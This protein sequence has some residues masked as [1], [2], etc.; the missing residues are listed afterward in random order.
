VSTSLLKAR[1]SGGSSS[2]SSSNKSSGSKSSSNLKRFSHEQ[3][4][5]KVAKRGPSVPEYYA[6][7]MATAVEEDDTG[8]VFDAKHPSWALLVTLVKAARKKPS[9]GNGSVTTLASLGLVNRSEAELAKSPP[10]GGIRRVTRRNNNNNKNSGSGSNIKAAVSPTTSSTTES[11]QPTVSLLSAQLAATKRN[12]S[13]SPGSK[14]Q[15]PMHPAYGA[16][17]ISDASVAPGSPSLRADF[18]LSA[19]LKSSNNISIINNDNVE[20]ATDGGGMTP[21]SPGGTRRRKN[22]ARSLRSASPND[23]FLSSLSAEHGE[24]T[25]EDLQLLNKLQAELKEPTPSVQT[26]R[27]ICAIITIPAHLRAHIWRILLRCAKSQVTV[28][29]QVAFDLPNQRVIKADIERTLPYLPVFQDKKVRND[30]EILLTQYCKTFS[31]SYKQ[32]MNYI[33]APFFVVGLKTRSEIYNSYCALIQYFLPNTF[34]DNEFG[35]LQCVFSLF[36]FLLLYHDPELCMFL[37]MHQMGPE[38][39][40][41]SW[42]ITLHANRCEMSVLLCLWDHLLLEI[43]LDPLLHY[44]V[45]LALL[46]SKR[47][48]L[49]AEQN[50]TL[51]ETLSKIHV[52]T[53]REVARI[54]A[55]AKKL[56]AAS[57]LSVQHQ[58]TSVTSRKIPVDSVEYETLLSLPCLSVAAEELVG[59][60]YGQP[61]P[62]ASSAASIKFIV[63]DCRPLVQFE[64]GHLPCAFHVDP[65]LLFNDQELAARIASLSSMRGCH[66]CFF[67]EGYAKHKAQAC[68]MLNLS[69]LKRGFKF[70]SNCEGGYERCHAI[71]ASSANMF[72]LVDHNPDKCHE[73]NSSSKKKRRQQQQQQQQQLQQQQL[74]SPTNS[75][76]GGLLSSLA[77]RLSGFVSGRKVDK[78]KNGSKKDSNKKQLVFETGYQADD[79]S[80]SSS[81]SL[82]SS[83]SSTAGATAA[84]PSGSSNDAIS[85]SESKHGGKRSNKYKQR[86]LPDNL[87]IPSFGFECKLLHTVLRDFSQS[88]PTFAAA[89]NRF[90]ALLCGAAM[91]HVEVKEKSV[92]NSVGTIFTGLQASP[93]CAVTL[94]SAGASCMR[95]ALA[96]FTSLIDIETGS[97]TARTTNGNDTRQQLVLSLPDDVRKR[98]VLVFAAVADP[99]S[100]IQLLNVMHELSNARVP[101]DRIVVVALVIARQ[102]LWTF[103]E[104]YPAITLV[105]SSVDEYQNGE[106]SPG[107]GDF[108]RRYAAAAATAAATSAASMLKKT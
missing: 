80:S 77:Q 103:A 53:K 41:S 43:E 89:A 88:G 90:A 30:M 98:H 2:S 38:L 85:S 54:V 35:G 106:L 29:S 69:F 81:S 22:K 3:I 96:P 31:V 44:F 18:R 42:F 36:R 21:L 70:I 10:P 95:A 71:I 1:A 24:V 64:A 39:Y 47:K 73:C 15:S 100:S 45:S 82:S 62:G 78:K 50:V 72:E 32:G 101:R 5:S 60:C 59:H 66:F 46:M 79:A 94:S 7:L 33:L 102:T 11:K 20:D 6:L 67:G 83:T 75:K 26:I 52:T 28:Q 48:L 14:R 9:A 63:L 61:L 16:H 12:D 76:K 23:E 37:D 19:A 91:D 99:S 34:T 86:H 107:L 93:M 68:T 40:A 87:I 58:F 8:I 51:P 57:P 17:P 65:V 84:A 92:M 105:V 4:R 104:N 27:S 49:L 74:N 56:R 13:S 108:A 55:H 25:M 97:V